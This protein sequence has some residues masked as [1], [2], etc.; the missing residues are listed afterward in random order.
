[1]A[2]SGHRTDVALTSA[3]D[4]KRTLGNSFAGMPIEFDHVRVSNGECGL[5]ETRFDVV[6]S[7]NQRSGFGSVLWWSCLAMLAIGAN[8]TAIMGR[9]ADYADRA[10][11]QP[12]RRAMGVNAYLIASAACIVPGGE[13]A[14]RFGAQPASLVGLGLFGV[15]SCIIAMADTQSALLAGRTLQGFAAAFEVPCTLAAVDTS[16]APERRAAAIGAFARRRSNWAMR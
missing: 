16:A 1:M 3:D 15:A 9:L 10:F 2:P 13:A 11:A 12:S 4:P 5:C 7:P 8:G 6:L 14:D